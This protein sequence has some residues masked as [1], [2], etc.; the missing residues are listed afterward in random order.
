MRMHAA[1]R[2]LA[3]GGM[4]LRFPSSH[5]VEARRAELEQRRAAVAFVSSIW[6][7]PRL[8]RAACTRDRAA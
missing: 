1:R 2:V 7:E 6:M 5:Y 3:D 4:R 8:T